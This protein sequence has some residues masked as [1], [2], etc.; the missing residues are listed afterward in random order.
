MLICSCIFQV[1]FGG[2]P[3]LYAATEWNVDGGQFFGPDGIMEMRRYPKKK[4]VPA[5][6]PITG[7]VPGNCGSYPKRLPVFV[8][9]LK[10]EIDICLKELVMDKTVQK[11][12]MVLC[13]WCACCFALQPEIVFD[14]IYGGSKIDGISCVTRT[15]AGS[16]LLGGFSN[17]FEGSVNDN[18]WNP[19][20]FQ[21]EHTGEMGWSHWY[22]QPC[23]ASVAA[24]EECA[25][26]SLFIACNTKDPDKGYDNVMVA[27]AKAD[28]DTLWQKPFRFYRIG[29]VHCFID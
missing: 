8:T 1:N 9:P 3:I 14:T 4:S 15:H 12:F 29:E 7:T 20:V 6:S 2:I 18:L 16:Y 24:I 23:R 28:G 5:S 17:S 13:V 21:I 10:N 27:R 11:M 26:G 19:W 22:T 25:D